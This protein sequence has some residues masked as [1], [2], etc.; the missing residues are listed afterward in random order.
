MLSL[1]LDIKFR[2]HILVPSQGGCEYVLGASEPRKMSLVHGRQ[3]KLII[4]TN[5][6]LL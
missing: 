6:K 1:P 3:G 2:L 4:I 5:D